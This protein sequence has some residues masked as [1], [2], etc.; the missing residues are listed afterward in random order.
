MRVQP[1]RQYSLSELAALTD[2]SRQTVW[3]WIKDRKLQAKSVPHPRNRGMI[4]WV[5]VGS[6]LLKFQ[7]A[8]GVRLAEGRPTVRIENAEE[9]FGRLKD[10]RI[11]EPHVGHEADGWKITVYR[12]GGVR[13]FTHKR[14]I[15]ALKEAAAA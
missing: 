9:L 14:L 2:V 6:D 4:M 3:K 7:A 12:R 11:Q 13:Q 1:T 8:Q 5:V 15:Q 10:V